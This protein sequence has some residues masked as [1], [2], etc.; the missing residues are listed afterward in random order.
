MKIHLSGDL[1]Y[2][3][4]KWI[5]TEMSYSCINELTGLL[6]QI[7][8]AGKKKL[9]V[10]CAHLDTI[11]AS[12]AHFLDIWLKCLKLRGVDHELIYIPEQEEKS[13][14]GI[15]HHQQDLS[16]GPFMRKSLPANQMK[17]R[18]SYE[19]RRDQGNSQAAS[20]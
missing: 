6:D 5:N 15:G 13:F 14:R 3:W 11:D 16:P 8:S 19:N 18:S 20:N 2:L 12:G 7:E 9:R 17:R 1:A 4:G 10:N